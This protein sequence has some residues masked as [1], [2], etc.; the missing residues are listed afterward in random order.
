MKGKKTQSTNRLAMVHPGLSTDRAFPPANRMAVL[1]GITLHAIDT[2][3][4]KIPP[5]P[6]YTYGIAK[7]VV[8]S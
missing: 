3:T 2:G 6:T 8:N 1:I 4:L 7:R 5:Y